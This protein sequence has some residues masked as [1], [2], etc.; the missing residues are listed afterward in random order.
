LDKHLHI[1]SFDVPYPADY[2]GVIDVYFKIKSLHAA[3]IKVHLHCFTK[4]REKQ[5]SLNTICASVHYYPRRKNAYSFLLPYIVVSRNDMHLWENI[6]NDDYPVLM[7]GIHCS[8]L[9]HQ[10]KLLHR[11]H[12]L[13]MHNV[14]FNY[15]CQL[16]K[17]EKN[18]LKKLFFSWQSGLLKA[19]EKRIAN[20][21]INI[22]LSEK[23]AGIYK[24]LFNASQVIIV[25]A[26]VGWQKPE[27]ISG[28]GMFCLYHGNLSINENENAA[29]WLIEEVFSQMDM[30]LVIAGKSPGKRLIEKVYKHN[31]ICLVSNPT[32]TELQ[33]LI[34][35]A[36][37]NVL[38]SMNNTG[39]KLKLL[40][41]LFAGRHALVNT[42]AV[43]G[44]GL[45]SVCHLATD[46]ISFQHQTRLL[47][48]KEYSNEDMEK[49]RTFLN[50]LY[51]NEANAAKLIA[52]LY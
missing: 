49:R 14:E 33:D 46:A 16:A 27:A 6:K 35:K 12:F 17:N 9:L 7:E 52:L 36:Q 5:S 47:Y 38:P 21:S 30:P 20:K 51:N 40:N 48:L 23:D 18:I 25:P 37:V 4:T 22:A 1:I 34:K 39:V 10:Q 15:Y 2:G 44:S 45:E 13:R 19:Y 41:A 43:E 50:T 24:N 3:G 11:K 32:E 26:F 31:N 29:I 42:A 28:K 8:M